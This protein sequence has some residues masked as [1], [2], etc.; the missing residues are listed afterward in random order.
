MNLTRKH[1]LLILQGLATAVAGCLLAFFWEPGRDPVSAGD[2][3]NDTI[4]APQGELIVP[5]AANPAPS[6]PAPTAPAAPGSPVAPRALP[7][8]ALVPVPAAPHTNDA[9]KLGF[10]TLASFAYAVRV[11]YPEG[12]QGRPGLVT[13]DHIPQRIRDLDGRRVAVDGYVMP[14]RTQGRGVLE[15]LLVR[16]SLTCCFGVSPLMN[17]WIYVTLPRGDFRPRI[18]QAATVTGTLRVGE[19]RK[20]GSIQ[21]IY[22]LEGE[23]VEAA[24]EPAAPVSPSGLKP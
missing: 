10:D 11:G 2:L 23:Q 18:F 16:D 13:D 5:L 8:S 17:H 6:N 19:L 14:L 1:G 3:L 22:R 7:G 12:G 20:A 4:L 21:S 24:S 9:L 15:F